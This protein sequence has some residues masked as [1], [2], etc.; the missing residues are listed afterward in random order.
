VGLVESLDANSA[1]LAEVAMK[2]REARQEV[3]GAADD[4]YVIR[5]I[6][7]ASNHD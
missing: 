7:F 2:Q 6:F 4:D 3:S 1:R 5:G